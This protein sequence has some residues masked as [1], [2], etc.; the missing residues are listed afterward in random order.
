MK[1][2]QHPVEAKSPAVV[3]VLDPGSS[4]VQVT[5]PETAPRGRNDVLS[6]YMAIAA[7]AFGLISD[8]CKLTSLLFHDNA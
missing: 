5:A 4:S 6:A 8:G 1:H 3:P 2:P 7:S